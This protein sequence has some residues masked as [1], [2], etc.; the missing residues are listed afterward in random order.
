MSYLLDRKA[1]KKK[2]LIALFCV[3]FLVVFFYFR[4]GIW[5]G[6]S[7]VGQKVFR[8]VIVGGNNV[9]TRLGNFGAYFYSKQMLLNEN[10][11]LRARLD[12]ANV[13]ILNHE[14]VDS[15]NVMLK[16]ILGRKKEEARMTLAT[17]LSKPNQSAYDTLLVDVGEDLGIKNGDMV[18][19]FGE[20]PI[21]KVGATSTQASTIILFSSA[22]ER[23]FANIL[24]NS[25]SEVGSEGVADKVIS[26]E[27]VGRGGG[28]FEMIFPR[29][30][31]INPGDQAILPG[32]NSYVVAV[33]EATISDPRDSFTKVL[34]ASPV[35]MQEL[36]FVQVKKD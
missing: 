8:P 36:K 3:L 35:N 31:T 11:D 29:D 2:F 21:G 32:I 7:Y 30:I 10:E 20:V 23:T 14:A 15:E 34:F 19:A 27:L 13:K 16:E 22:G 18:F 5:N 1:K 17:V 4:N 25:S 6:F 9:G 28:N 24:R 12:E 26:S 33:A